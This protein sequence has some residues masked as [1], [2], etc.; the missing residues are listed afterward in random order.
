MAKVIRNYDANVAPTRSTSDSSA[1][2]TWDTQSTAPTLAASE[3][4]ST[5]ATSSA[6]ERSTARKV[7]DKIKKAAKEHHE[8]VN[9]AYMAYYAPGTVKYEYK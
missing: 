9:E 4:A 2:A 7:W 1:E 6:S 5:K 3:T 8:S